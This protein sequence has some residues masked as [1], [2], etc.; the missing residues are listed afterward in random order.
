[1]RSLRS[2]E[3][4]CVQAADGGKLYDVRLSGGLDGFGPFRSI[5]EFHLFLRSGISSSPEQYSEVN[6]L[7]DK[8][9]SARYSTRFTH[10]DLNSTNILV[11]DDDIVGIVDWDTAGWLPEYWEYTTASNV[12]PYNEFWKAEI[13]KFLQEYPE[14]LHTESLR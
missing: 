1:M 10:S 6:E 2:A 11:R 7:V 13:L 4:G 14:A 3:Q 9:N 12:N 8:H 5:D